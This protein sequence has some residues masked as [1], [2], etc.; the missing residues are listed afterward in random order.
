MKVNYEVSYAGQT[1]VFTNI[2]VEDKPTDPVQ[3]E[4]WRMEL[5]DNFLGNF[6]LSVVYQTTGEEV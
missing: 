5:I 6:Q 4:N 1:R 3:Q 2:E